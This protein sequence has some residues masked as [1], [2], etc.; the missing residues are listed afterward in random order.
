MRRLSKKLIIIFIIIFSFS[1]IGFYLCFFHNTI[2]VN[3]ANRVTILTNCNDS[4]IT[5]TDIVDEYLIAELKS[6]F[7]GRIFLDSPSCG[8]SSSISIIMIGDEGVIAFSPAL[9]GCPI[10][11]IN[12]SNEFMRITEEQRDLINEIF[13][14]FSIAFPF[15]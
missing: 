1:I 13:N 12:D 5:E 3:S 7:R 6:I 11:R 15:V 14:E 4:N 10:I 8:F 9:D 2:N